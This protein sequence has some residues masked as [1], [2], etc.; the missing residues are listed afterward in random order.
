MELTIHYKIFQALHK[1]LTR[2]KMST[3]IE[4]ALFCN[5]SLFFLEF[6]RTFGYPKTWQFSTDIEIL[7]NCA[8]S[9]SGFLSNFAEMF[10]NICIHSSNDSCNFQRNVE[11]RSPCQSFRSRRM[12]QISLE[13]QNRLWYSRERIFHSKV[14]V[15]SN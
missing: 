2:H 8:K 5:M 12:L 6:K 10:R 3:I 1:Y 4:L 14:W 13:L 7:Q 15:I 9:V 11:K